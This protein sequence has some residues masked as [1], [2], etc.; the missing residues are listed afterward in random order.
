VRRK[1][2]QVV[3][4]D[5]DFRQSI[6]FILTTEGYL[7][8][9]FAEIPEGTGGGYDA[10]VLDHRAARGKPQSMVAS[11]CKQASP[12]VL[13]GAAPAEWLADLAYRLVRLPLPGGALVAAVREATPCRVSPDRHACGLIR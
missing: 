8:T 11:F 13:L 3:A 9:S 12:V 7:V 5:D 6:V 1:S 10:T 4:V 2:L